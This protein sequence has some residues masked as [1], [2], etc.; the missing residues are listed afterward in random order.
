MRVLIVGAG[1]IAY[2]HAAAGRDLDGAELTAV[3]DVRREAAEALADRFGV[4]ARYVD[5]DAL[6]ERETA[7]LAIVATW[8]IHHAATVER[9][10]RSGRVKA[11][12][13]EKPLAMDA[14]QAAAMAAVAAEQ[15]V[16]LAEAFRLRHQPIHHRA[17]GIIRAGGIGEVRHV[18][19]AMMW[20]IP[21]ENRDPATNWRF[22]QS[23]GGGVTY[24][25]GCYCIN[26]LRWAFGAE[27]E[28]VHAL[29][30]RGPTGVDEHVVAL[31]AFSEGRTAEWCVSWQAGPRH[32]AEVMGTAGSLRIE[33]AWGDNQNTAT[34]LERFDRDRTRTVEEFPPTDQ[35]WLQLRHMQECLVSGVP[36]RVP[37]SDSVAQMRVI[38][39]VYASMRAGG[40]VRV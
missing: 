39:A 4:E 7:D 37:P 31:A 3:C 27:P 22:N 26:Q 10:A 23:V 9:L 34:V 20:R 14:P 38:D 24:D 2:R 35:F 13:C 6:L 36:H 1:A 5:L 12:L 33:N 16:L 11:I 40:P 18:R 19:N 32:V 30:A 29:G 21:D 15:G 28:T 25:I 8:G 17:I